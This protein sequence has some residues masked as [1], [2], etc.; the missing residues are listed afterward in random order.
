MDLYQVHGIAS[1]DMSLKNGITVGT[2][3]IADPE[4]SFPSMN[5]WQRAREKVMK[6]EVGMG[7]AMP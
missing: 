4:K 6:G 5:L 2:K 3:I 1:L 7:N